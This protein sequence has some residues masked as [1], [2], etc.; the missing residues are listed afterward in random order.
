MAN[1]AKDYVRYRSE[2]SFVSQ[3]YL[4][5]F[6]L[7]F[8]QYTLVLTINKTTYLGFRFWI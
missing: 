2:P 7:L 8:M 1:N 3:R 6:L 5:K 4:V